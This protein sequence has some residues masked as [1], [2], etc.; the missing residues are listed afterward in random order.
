MHP[1]QKEILQEEGKYKRND[2]RRK[3][4]KKGARKEE[5]KESYSDASVSCCHEFENN[6][7]LYRCD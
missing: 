5:T 1:K 6:Y 2:E 3:E 4:N 7:I